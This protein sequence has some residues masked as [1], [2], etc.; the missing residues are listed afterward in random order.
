MTFT[1]SIRYATFVNACQS[2][3]TFNNFVAYKMF[4]VKRGR[5]KLHMKR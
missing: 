3:Q 4:L 1:H 5:N 2:T